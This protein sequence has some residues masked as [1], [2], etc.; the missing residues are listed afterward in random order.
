[1]IINES[2]NPYNKIAVVGL[3]VSGRSALR[4]LTFLEKD[5][6]LVNQGEVETWPRYEETRSILGKVEQEN[7]NE[8]LKEMDLIILSPGISKDIDIFDGVTCPIWCEIELA[9]K[10][11]DAPILGV[12]GTN[13]KTTVVSFL[14]ECAKYDTTGDYFIGGN[15]GVPFCDYI[16]ER[17]SG[18]RE[19]AQGIILEL[20]SF[21]L[22]LIEEFQCDVAGL[23]NL[24]F[25]HG[26]RYHNIEEYGLDKYEIF[27]NM[28]N[29]GVAYYPSGLPV[30]I[31]YE[32]RNGHALDLD[33][34]K[35]ISELSS[36]I[37]VS[38]L[39]IF[40]EHNIIN[41][42]FVYLLWDAFTG[43]IDA[44]KGAC[45]SFHGVEYR[46]QLIKHESDQY[47][48]NDAK[49]TNWDST[50]IAL[51]GVENLGN[52]D[53]IIGGQLRGEGDNQLSRL[54]EF[55][56]EIRKIYFFG[57]SGKILSNECREIDCE[58]YENLDDVFK[59]GFEAK[60]ILFSPA[61]PSFD[62][63]LN[64]IKRGEHFTKLALT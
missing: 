18:E 62:Q 26:E 50:C 25:S 48:F 52:V 3:G 57:E 34:K 51:K 11:A 6:Y 29:G 4:L 21:Q 63:Y 32:M 40:G 9:Y 45:E 39:K 5:V 46:L 38:K 2:L 12:T 7:S 37:D 36:Y 42:Y 33:M 14:A 64:Y 15:I 31:P 1:M 23:L 8:L 19:Q 27:K 54:D 49:S 41:T 10:F 28:Q 59:A 22:N 30:A 47:F 58:Y 56:N 20:S 13:G 35:I 60:V 55:K 24:T 53:L 44:F 61:F 16:Y 17:M 43:N